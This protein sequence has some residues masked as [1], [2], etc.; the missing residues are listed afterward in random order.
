MGL[1]EHVDGEMELICSCCQMLRGK[2]LHIYTY[3]CLY[4]CIYICVYMYIYLFICVYIYTHYT[5]IFL[6]IFIGFS[7]Q[8]F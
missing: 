6:I 2:K 8:K 3:M 5:Y 7:L 4:I 1:T